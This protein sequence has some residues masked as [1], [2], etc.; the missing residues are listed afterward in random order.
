M[1]FLRF[2]PNLLVAGAVCQLRK[3]IV[4]LV[5][6]YHVGRCQVQSVQATTVHLALQQV[7]S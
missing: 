1:K 4:I 6:G 5:L 3:R 7:D 2:S